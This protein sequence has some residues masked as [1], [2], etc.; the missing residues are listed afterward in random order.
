VF[1]RPTRGGDARACSR[2]RVPPG[3]KESVLRRRASESRNV[4]CAS[5]T[6]EIS[7]N[8]MT[9]PSIT[10]SRVLYG[11]MRSRYYSPVFVCTS[12]SFGTKLSNTSR[13]SASKRS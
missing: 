6:M 7:V 8:V 11:R 10:F 5:F 9:A 12:I 2:A 13:M 3:S 1:A 4:A